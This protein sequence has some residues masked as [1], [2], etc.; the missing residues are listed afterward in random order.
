[1]NVAVTETTTLDEIEATRTEVRLIM[2]EEGLTQADIAR[3][4]GIPYGTFTPFMGGTYKG[5]NSGIAVKVRRWLETRRERKRTH[6]V[7]PAAPVFVE[8]PT[9]LNIIEIM[10]F[11]QVAPDMGVVVG[12]AGLGKT[13]A[14]EKYRKE[15]SNVFVV[16]AEPCLSTPNNML[17]AIA[18]ELGVIERRN[19]FLSRAIVN[20]LRGA[21]ALLVI[22]EAQHLSSQALDQLRTIHDKARC[23]VIVA[24]NESVFARLQGGETKGAQFAQLHSRVGMR[25]VQAQPRAKDICAL[26]AAWGID[27]SSP[28]AA[29]L[30]VI[31]R[32]PGALRGLT[33]VV[34]VASML[35][36]GSA[37]P[38]SAGHIR[39][40]WAQLS[41]SSS[42]D[43]AA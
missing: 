35:A 34:R 42:L 27:G 38:L 25:I 16:T 15:N 5:D 8:T 22:D 30:K 3:E 11:A 1:M 13:T 31:A 17:S 23:G 28:E 10:S 33:K 37:E 7:L 9:A 41:S 36:S 32:K 14:I 24:G 43:E 2:T 20:R 6:A 21:G 40:A 39:R 19:A 12:G 29:L 4:A 18:D 26:I